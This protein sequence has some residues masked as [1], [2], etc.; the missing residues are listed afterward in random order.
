MSKL[1]K[2]RKQWTKEGKKVHDAYYSIKNCKPIADKH[3]LLKIINV[4]SL[5]CE[6][7]YA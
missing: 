3:I 5:V 6:A 2:R 7:N 4:N 1:G